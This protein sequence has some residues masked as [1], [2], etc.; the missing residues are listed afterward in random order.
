MESWREKKIDNYKRIKAK[1][2]EVEKKNQV[3]EQDF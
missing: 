2:H 3:I 1:N